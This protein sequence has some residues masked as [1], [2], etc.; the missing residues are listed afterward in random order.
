MKAGN[1]FR[2]ASKT[3][4]DGVKWAKNALRRPTT[5]S[6]S[7]RRPPKRPRRPPEK[8]SKGPQEVPTKHPEPKKNPKSFQ[9][10]PVPSC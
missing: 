5:P 2:E 3:V 6:K 1:R 7:P 10:C 8:H 9:T 4:S